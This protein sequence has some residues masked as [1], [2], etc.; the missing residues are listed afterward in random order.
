MAE[1]FYDLLGFALAEQTVVYVNA[2]QVFADS[3]DKQRRD[4]RRIHAA[5]KREQN[6]FIADLSAQR[7][8]LFGYER[9]GEFFCVDPLHRFRS[10]VFRHF[11][12]LF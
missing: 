3:F 2:Y 6:F 11:R 10:S 12:Y 8:D 7:C 9:V 4:Y 1:H 5:G